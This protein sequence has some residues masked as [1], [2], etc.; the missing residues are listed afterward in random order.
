MTSSDIVFET[1]WFNVERQT[2]DDIEALGGKP[3]YR[4]NAPDGVMVLAMTGRNQLVMVEQFR[5]ALCEHTLELPAGARDPDETPEQTAAREL[6]EETGYVCESLIP[7]GAG[8]LMGSRFNAYQFPF[9]GL[10]A[11]LSSSHVPRENIQV[12]LVSP[13]ELKRLTLNQEFVQYT[14][15]ALMILA[16]WQVGTSL[17]QPERMTLKSDTQ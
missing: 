12:R 11:K 4:I 5:P 9:L 2:Y 14:A 10:G 17:T 13:E 16:D 3:F 8:R 6:Y 1:E 7:L 15:L